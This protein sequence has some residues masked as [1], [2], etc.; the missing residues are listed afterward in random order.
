MYFFFTE[1]ARI[2]VSEQEQIIGGFVGKVTVCKT[3][4]I[5]FLSWIQ[6]YIKEQLETQLEKKMEARDGS[7]QQQDLMIN[8]PTDDKPTGYTQIT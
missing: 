8:L 6:Y 2:K 3:K 5:L 4:Y 1:R 7:A